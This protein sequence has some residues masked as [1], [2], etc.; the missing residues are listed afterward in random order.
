[1][2]TTPVIAQQH[3]QRFRQALESVRDFDPSGSS[4]AVGEI[5]ISEHTSVWRFFLP[6]FRALVDITRPATEDPEK[7]SL[8]LHHTSGR[9]SSIP[10]G[11]LP[12]EVCA[13]TADIF[14]TSEQQTVRRGIAR[15]PGYRPTDKDLLALAG[16]ANTIADGLP[17][18]AS[19]GARL[20][21]GVQPLLAAY[22]LELLPSRLVDLARLEP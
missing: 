21:D 1:M 22:E 18:F 19:R 12:E 6:G 4:D 10:T 7:I 11:P 14:W 20:F 8:W 13:L 16:L 3:R 2:K 15:Y 9:I 5:S 17:N